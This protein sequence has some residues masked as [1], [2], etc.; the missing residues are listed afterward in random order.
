[1]TYVNVY[2]DLFVFKGY[3]AKFESWNSK[4]ENT[5]NFFSRE[6]L[7]RQ[8]WLQRLSFLFN[9]YSNNCQKV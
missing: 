1:M 2:H 5:E 9:M 8:A 3:L 6:E 4:L 7:E